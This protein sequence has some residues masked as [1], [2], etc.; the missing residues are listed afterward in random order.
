MHDYAPAEDSTDGGSA[1]GAHVRRRLESARTSLA[2]QRTLLLA[3]MA[4]VVILIIDDVLFSYPLPLRV[5]AP[6]DEVAHAATMVVVLC[7]LAR[8]VPRAFVAGSLLGAVMLDIDHLSI[9]WQLHAWAP[10]HGRPY[11]HSLLMVAVVALLMCLPPRWRMVGIGLVCGLLSHLFRDLAT[12]VVPLFW[13]LASMQFSIP[14]SLYEAALI[15][16][17]GWTVVYKQG[18]VGEVET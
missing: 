5:T 1:N 9:V 16:V 4:A 8:R 7:A 17:L 10:V 15:G 14:H 3:C 6:L 2:G 11:S 18:E 13:P 12:G